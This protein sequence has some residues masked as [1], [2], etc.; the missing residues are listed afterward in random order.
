[1][2][3]SRTTITRRRGASSRRT[4]ISNITNLPK[5]H[6]TATFNGGT[7]KIQNHL[8]MWGD[9]NGRFVLDGPRVHLPRIDINTDGAAD[10]GVGRRG[11]LA[12][13]GH[14]YTT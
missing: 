6:G 2:A 7:I 3:S 10:D 11:L 9:F 14:A 13:A 5:Y 12:L 1:M 8:P 4:S